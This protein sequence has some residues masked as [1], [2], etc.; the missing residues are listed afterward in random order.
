MAEFIVYILMLKYTRVHRIHK[1]SL[2]M[3]AHVIYK[4]DRFNKDI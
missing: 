2:E 1:S 4:P 3:S